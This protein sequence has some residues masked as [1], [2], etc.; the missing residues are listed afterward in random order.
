MMANPSPDA[1]VS[2]TGTRAKVLR[3]TNSLNNKQSKIPVG[4]LGKPDEIAE[5]VL[6]LASNGYMT[7]KVGA[8]NHFL[9]GFRSQAADI[10]KDY[11]RRWRLDSR[12]VLNI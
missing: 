4:R 11:R 10:L 6:L 2:V 5:V 9:V 1:R 7:N 8:S 12:R 3:K